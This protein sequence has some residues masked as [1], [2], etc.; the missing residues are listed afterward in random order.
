M[1]VWFTIFLLYDNYDEMEFWYVN[2]QACP[3]IL[4]K[5]HCKKKLY[6]WLVDLCENLT[7]SSVSSFLLRLPSSVSLCMQYIICDEQVKDAIW[8]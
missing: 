7:V 5:V 2:F 3:V 8:V 6:I 1:D 4:N